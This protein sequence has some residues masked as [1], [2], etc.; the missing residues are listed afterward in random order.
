MGMLG[1]PWGL[2]SIPGV[3]S[4]GMQT[5]EGCSGYRGGVSGYGRGCCPPRG[6]DMGYRPA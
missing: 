2:Q 5:P 1:T 4:Q 6:K 3:V